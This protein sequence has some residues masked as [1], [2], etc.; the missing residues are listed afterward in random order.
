MTK[1]NIPI[2]KTDITTVSLHWGLVISLVFSLL[3]GLRI[4]AD[5]QDSFRASALSGIL[6]QGDVMHWHIWAAY[7]LVLISVAYIAFI[8]R[9]KLKSRITIDSVRLKGLVSTDPVV[10]WKSF[11]ILLY[12]FAFALLAVS[13][14]TGT[15]LYVFPGLLPHYFVSLVHAS[16]AWL[17]ILYI[18]LH[19]LSQLAQGGL[20]QLLKILNPKIAYGAAATVA[21][22][23]SVIVG[24]GVYTVDK[25]L[26]QELVVVKTDD[27][28][29]I[30]GNPDDAVWQQAQRVKIHTSRGINQPSGE[31]AV[32]L[33]MVHDNINLYA[34]FEWPDATRSQK[35]LPLQKTENGWRVIQTEYGIQDEDNY[36]EDKFGVMLA[37]S[38][39]IGGAG[40]S[41]L[42]PKP[43]DN[44]PAPSGGRGLHYTTDGSVVDVWH[45]KSVRSGSTDMNQIDDNYF[46]PPLKPKAK[47]GRYTGGY[48]KDP[49]TAGGFKMNWEKYSDDIIT[50]LRL[51]KDPNVLN[52]LGDVNLNP[53]VG[54]AGEI[55]LPMDDTVPYSKELDTYPVGT[56]MPSVLVSGPFEGDRGDVRTV[57]RWKDGWWRLEVTR[58]LDTGS[59]FDTPVTEKHPTYLWVVVFD[60]AQTR[61]SMHL[62]PVRLIKG[63]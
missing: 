32:S 33:R 39:A 41:H 31:V 23:I 40:T 20:K 49:K 60:H 46:G 62:H 29:V 24:I 1:Q 53:N 10:R 17:I 11:N 19:V 7:A 45:W 43:L 59:K 35:H 27:I 42:G 30:D 21:L 57:A 52:R 22:L 14:I 26:I 25:S 3:T 5:A 13:A 51:P 6:L 55:W 56:I 63:N 36:Y 58:K 18:A 47:G 37:H 44:K 54:D 4:S 16:V 12:G 50:P 8:I 61:H 38:P 2:Q 15:V 48:T 28:P 34:L 9:A